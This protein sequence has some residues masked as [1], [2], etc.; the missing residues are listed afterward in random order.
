MRVLLIEDD[1]TIAR[2]LKE[3]LEDESYAVD[4]AHDGGEGYRTAAA[5]EYDVIITSVGGCRRNCRRSY[6]ISRYNWYNGRG[7]QESSNK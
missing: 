6:S 5:D 1:V 3:G 7:S 2:L 4:V